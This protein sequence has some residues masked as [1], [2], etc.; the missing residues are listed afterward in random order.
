MTGPDDPE[1]TRVMGEAS[2]RIQA[3]HAELLDAYPMLRGNLS[4]PGMFIGHGLGSFVANGMPDDQ[5]VV[6]V[7]GIAA[8]IREIGQLPTVH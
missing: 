5:I 1:F 8:Q 7:L 4:V 2:A 6:H 3:L